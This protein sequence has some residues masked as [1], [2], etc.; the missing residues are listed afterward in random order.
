MK[1]LLLMVF[2]VCPSSSAFCAVRGRAVALKIKRNRSN[3]VMR[4]LFQSASDDNEKKSVTGTIYSE[5]SNHPIVSLYTKE[6]CTLCDKAVDILKSIRVEQPH[7]LRSIDI[8]D[9]DK[10]VYWDKYKWDIPVL[11]INGMYWQKQMSSRAK[12][13]IKSQELRHLYL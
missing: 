13:K 2:L 9:E 1:I 6:G 5:E 8:T 12:G 4:T 7:T 11:H 10:H 3:V